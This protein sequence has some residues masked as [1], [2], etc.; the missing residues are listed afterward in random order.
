MATLSTPSAAG[1]IGNAAISIIIPIQLIVTTKLFQTTQS[2]IEQMAT[3]STPSA[4][5]EKLTTP[6][7]R[8]MATG[9]AELTRQLVS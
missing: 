1:Q 8:P 2:G 6:Q 9:R 7:F 3:L 5:G 4:A